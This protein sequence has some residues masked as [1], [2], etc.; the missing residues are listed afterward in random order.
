MED[1]TH[2]HKPVAHD[3]ST[4]DIDFDP[5][6]FKLYALALTSMTHNTI[7][8]KLEIKIITQINLMDSEMKNTT[9]LSIYLIN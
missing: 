8:W 7:Y 9:R 1:D 6:S 2:T 5:A 3:E 4:C